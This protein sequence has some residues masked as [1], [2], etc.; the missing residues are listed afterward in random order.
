M[1]G[2]DA[3]EK[4][5]LQLANNK[6]TVPMNTLFNC[7]KILATFVLVMM[8]LVLFAQEQK[9]L[10]F[11]E[12]VSY[13]QYT[14]KRHI[15]CHDPSVVWEPTKERFY[16]FGSH[17]AQAYTADLQ[18]W[19]EFRAPWGTLQA[20]GSIKSGAANIEAFV[21][22]EVKSVSVGGREVPFG[23]YDAHAWVSA[24]GD[25]YNVDG[26]LWAPDVIYNDAM[27][28]WCMYMSVNGPNHNCVIVLLT[29]DKID[30]TYVYQGPVV[31]T[32][33]KSGTDARVSWKN[34]DLELVLGVQHTLPQRYEHPNGMSWGDYWPNGID[35]CVFYDEEGNL[36]MAYGSWSG[37]IWMIELDENTG[38]RDYNVVYGSDYAAQ[39]KGVSEDPYFGKKI[40]GGYYVSGEAA[41]IE[42]IGGYY[43]LFMSYGY[44]DSVGGY[45]MRVFR[46][47]SP[48][49]PYVDAQGR[50]AIFD[51]YVMNYGPS[52]DTRGQLIMGAYDKWGFMDKGELAQGHN[53]VIAAPDGRSYLVYHTRFND[54]T[55]G[56]QVR[57]HQLFLNKDGWLVASPF[58]YNG[59][60]TTDELIASEETI[61]KT[62]IPGIY[63]LLVHQYGLN[64]KEREVATPVKVQLHG[65]GSISGAYDGSWSIEAGTGYITIKLGNVSYS[66]VIVEEQMDKMNLIASTFT[67]CASDGTHIWGYKLRGDYALAYQLR[68]HS[69]PVTNGQ[70]VSAN[71]NLCEIPLIDNVVMEWSSSHPHIISSG[72]RYNPAG[73]TENVDVELC[74]H[75]ASGNYFCEQT[76]A[77]KARK[78]SQSSADWSS[79][80][81]AYYDF[82][83]YTPTNSVNPT[84]SASFLKNGVNEAPTLGSDDIRNGSYVHLTFGANGHESYVSLPNPFYREEVDA[85]IT[86]SFWLKRDDDNLWDALFAFYNGSDNSRFYMAGGSYMGYN[87]GKGNWIDV[88]YP[89]SYTGTPI[90]TGRWCLVNL[91]LSR[92]QGIKLYIDGTLVENYTYAGSLNGVDVVKGSAF[93][94]NLIVDHIA[95]CPKFTLGCGSFWG[96]PN[97]SIDD[98]ILHNRVLNRSEIRA[99]KQIMNRVYDI[100]AVADIDP[101]I[102][103]SPVSDSLYD[104]TGRRVEYPQSGIYI[105]GGKKI[106]IR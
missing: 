88:N 55:E 37:G 5:I 105:Q 92:S 83:S 44:L 97:V 101:I 11:A 28:K 50:S 102:T 2:R 84:E 66:G 20:D 42:H 6:K 36:W 71:L 1:N 46:S 30:G 103:S 51:R 39:Q 77:V 12:A 67:A 69:I 104:L 27:Q 60:T 49:G 31:Y 54:G 100:G 25:G 57:V 34:T 53:S 47:K 94:Y 85:G 52:A 98:L 40:A 32:G 96:S 8:S 91:T 19:T 9:E 65:D 18:S 3:C 22:H 87:N 82:D 7:K 10:T 48:N 74:M 86:L 24:Y 59:G 61:S 106:V 80:I 73:L 35:P 23:N 43:F 58:E 14:N 16:I 76:Y 29:S 68:N 56:H 15:S 70:T 78:D 21:T 79:G 13:Y 81:V 99:L 17:L 38:L 75:V 63:H 33:F 4:M 90:S 95:S 26:N 45:Q 41:Y 64:Y 72:G 89:I 93:D 62:E